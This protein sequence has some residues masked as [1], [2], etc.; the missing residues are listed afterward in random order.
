MIEC[1]DLKKI[2]VIKKNALL[3]ANDYISTNAI[4]GL[5]KYLK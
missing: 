2:K 5:I 3:K 1:S 4:K